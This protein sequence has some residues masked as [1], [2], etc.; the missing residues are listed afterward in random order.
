[1]KYSK[2]LCLFFV[3]IAMLAM[4]GC[5]GGG[6]GS[7]SNSNPNSVL[8]VSVPLPSANASS[9]VILRAVASED[10]KVKYSVNGTEKDLPSSSIQGLDT[11][12]AN[13]NLEVPLGANVL[14]KS[15]LYNK[16]YYQGIACPTQGSQNI[17]LDA[18]TTAKA[19]IYEEKTTL[20]NNKNLSVASFET[21]LGKQN[22]FTALGI[23]E[24]D[25]KNALKNTT[26]EGNASV[27]DV[28]TKE[29]AKS[30]ASE[31]V[32]PDPNPT[33]EDGYTESGLTGE[34]ANLNWKPIASLDEVYE[35]QLNLSP[36]IDK[37]KFSLDSVNL[38]IFAD[39]NPNS[40]KV[41]NWKINNNK[42]FLGIIG[43][44][45]SEGSNGSKKFISN[46]LF[47]TE[48][49]YTC[50][51]AGYYALQH[52]STKGYMSWYSSEFNLEEYNK[53]Y[54]TVNVRITNGKAEVRYPFKESDGKTNVLGRI[55]ANPYASIAI[56]KDGSIYSNK[57][58]VL[59]IRIID[60]NTHKGRIFDTNPSYIA[61]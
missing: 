7:S 58:P 53:G 9:R 51:D 15:T 5:G 13:F 44:Q 21:A 36:D 45:M 20:D 57:E 50:A 12:T 37:A 8:K 23:E 26:K 17:A 25:V 19:M 33:S 34:L 16:A 49:Y 48:D 52:N 1:M 30:A 38:H 40:N 3:S 35:A 27:K 39:G 29:K 32:I 6:G 59:F 46:P 2:L 28:I 42:E 54:V 14:I 47:S 60:P 43:P 31:L 56:N 11:E 61:K 22:I 4:L 55:I 41:R 10:F 24:N 18:A